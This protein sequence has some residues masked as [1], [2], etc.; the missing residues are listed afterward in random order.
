MNKRQ[1]KKVQK[2]EQLFI[3]FFVSSYRELKKMNRQYH[4]YRIKHEHCARR[5]IGCIHSI[6][7][8]GVH[9]TC[10]LIFVLGNCE[11]EQKGE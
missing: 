11:Y 8:N 9:I 5:C 1:K 10:E 4:E 7:E 6:N 2:K 3:D